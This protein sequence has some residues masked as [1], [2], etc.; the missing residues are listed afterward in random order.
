MWH[1]S[2]IGAPKA[3]DG[4]TVGI[5]HKRCN[6]MDNVAFVIPLVARAKRL[7]R[8]HFG[9]TGP[10]LGDNPLPAGRRS[11]VTKK[12]NGTVEPRLT[13]AQKHRRTMAALYP[14]GT[15]GVSR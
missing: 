13:Q 1:E 10:G 9:I 4:E 7:R 5:A 8:R 2:H 14:F 6:E 3:L 15:R 12:L 11:N